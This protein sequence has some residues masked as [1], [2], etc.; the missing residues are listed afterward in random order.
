MQICRRISELILIVYSPYNRVVLHDYIL[1]DKF[2]QPVK[3][4]H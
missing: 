2:S 1:N 4:R 3:K